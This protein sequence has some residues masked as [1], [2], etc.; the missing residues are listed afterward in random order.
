MTQDKIKK[1]LGSE[2]MEFINSLNPEQ[3]AKMKKALKVDMD[4]YK[5]ESQTLFNREIELKYIN[6]LLNE[7]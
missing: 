7:N 5:H 3:L 6:Y 4:N 2:L 1:Y